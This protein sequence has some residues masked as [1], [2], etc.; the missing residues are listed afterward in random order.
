M[1]LAEQQGDWQFL[2][3]KIDHFEA[4]ESHANKPKG[5]LKLRVY[6]QL[7]IAEGR[8]GKDRLHDYWRS[9]S[10]SERADER[11]RLAYAKALQHLGDNESC[12]KVVYKGLKRGQLAIEQVVNN[13]ALCASYTKLLEFV[14][15]ALKRNPD[16]SGYIR[17]LAL[18]AVDS[19][20]YSL[21]QRALRK[22]IDSQA[23]AEDYKLL[24]DVYNALGD[25][26][27]AANAY[28]KA[29]A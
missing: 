12:A 8:K 9:L 24:G 7:F 15:D 23:T 29:L 16:H 25:S 1:R 22:L 5:D 18:L 28:Q 3:E 17:A 6:Q 13:K 21:A 11:I 4:L 14:Q 20:D 10:R 27:L 19:K 2:G 26:Q